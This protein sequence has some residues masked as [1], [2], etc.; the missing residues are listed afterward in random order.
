LIF[1]KGFIIGISIA[2][3]VGPIG[4]LFSG[5]GLVDASIHYGSASLMVIGVFLG[6][7]TWWLFLSGGTNLFRKKLNL[8]LVWINKLS[9]VV[10]TLFGV[11]AVASIL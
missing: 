8:R 1:L 10:I 5:F 9:G 7:A 2:A 11:I 3:P 6:S 4:I